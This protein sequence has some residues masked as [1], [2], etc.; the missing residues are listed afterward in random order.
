MATCSVLIGALNAHD[1]IPFQQLRRLTQEHVVR[2]HRLHLSWQSLSEEQPVQPP[3]LEDDD[4]DDDV[5]G[6][7]ATNFRP[8][9]VE[10]WSV[11]S[12]MSASLQP[13]TVC[14]SLAHADPKLPLPAAQE[15]PSFAPQY[16]SAPV[17]SVV[18]VP[19]SL[20]MGPQLQKR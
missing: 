1:A 17:H 6:G 3:L 19:S 4:D 2:S 14:S 10:R 15:V 16:H 12:L 9:Q 13:V 7:G 11:V 5:D 8:A 18:S 20:W